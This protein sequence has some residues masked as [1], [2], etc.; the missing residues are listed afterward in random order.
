[1][2]VHTQSFNYFHVYKVERRRIEY[3]SSSKKKKR[4]KVFF[5][6]QKRRQATSNLVAI[7][8]CTKLDYFHLELQPT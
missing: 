2:E 6:V 1:M 5:I 7:V 4:K 3:R 8:V